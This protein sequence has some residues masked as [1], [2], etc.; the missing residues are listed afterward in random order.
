VVLAILGSEAEFRKADT[1]PREANLDEDLS[2]QWS[3]D[4]EIVSF[5]AF[6]GKYAEATQAL[7][8]VNKKFPQVG[9]YGFLNLPVYNRIKDEYPAFKEAIDQ[10]K[11]PPRIMDTKLIKM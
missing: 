11:L 4:A 3:M 6:S 8:E 10:L 2:L 9:D 7:R 1:H 5:Y